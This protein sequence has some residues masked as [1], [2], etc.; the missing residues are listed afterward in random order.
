[1]LEV[2]FP[3]LPDRLEEQVFMRTIPL[4]QDCTSSI[5]QHLD[6]KDPELLGTNRGDSQRLAAP[7]FLTMEYN[8]IM[9]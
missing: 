5:H 7:L 9:K 4:V 2:A 1:M 8:I 6:L 3:L